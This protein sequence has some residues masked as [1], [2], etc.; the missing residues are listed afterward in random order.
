MTELPSR[1]SFNCPTEKPAFRE[2]RSDDRRMCADIPMNG[3]FLQMDVDA[4]DTTWMNIRLRRELAIPAVSTL[5]KSF[6]AALPK[7]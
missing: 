4:I 2:Y 7:D 3:E 6:S 1:T 5:D